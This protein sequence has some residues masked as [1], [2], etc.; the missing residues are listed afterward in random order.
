MLDGNPLVDL[1]QTR[2]LR[3]VVK[4]GELFDATTLDLVWPEARPLPTPF[5]WSTE[6]Q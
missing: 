2:S 5:R 1:R 3:Y 6:P 4:N